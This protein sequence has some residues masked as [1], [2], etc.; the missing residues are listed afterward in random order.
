MELGLE[1]VRFAPFGGLMALLAEPSKEMGVDE[2]HAPSQDEWAAPGCIALE[3]N[4]PLGRE[5]LSAIGIS[6]LFD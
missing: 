2:V 1:N 5:R 4:S 3:T 6:V